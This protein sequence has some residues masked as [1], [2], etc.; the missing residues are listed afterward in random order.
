MRVNNLAAAAVAAVALTTAGPA[1]AYCRTASCPNK[2]TGA[3]CLPMKPSDCGIPIAWRTPCIGFSVQEDASSQVPLALAEELFQTA[4]TTWMTADCGGGTF[5]RIQIVYAGPVVCAD[6]E[7]NQTL[8]NANTIIFRDTGWPYMGADSTLALTTVTYNL[9][10]GDIYDADIE[11]NSSSE[12]IVFTTGDTGV[13][14]DLRSIATHEVGHFLGLSHSDEDGATMNRGYDPGTIDLRDLE[15]D[16]VDAICTT[17]PPGEVAA[18]D[19]DPTP[20]HGFA[21]ECSVD[22]EPMEESGCC[23]IAPGAAASAPGAGGPFSAG[24][25][26]GALALGFGGLLLCAARLRRRLAR[27]RGAERGIGQWPEAPRPRLP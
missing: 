2:M 24:S 18:A 11:V 1:S 20:R 27:P 16:D 19:C 7:Y 25:R 17:Y 22:Q 8:G 3:Q 21:S 4:F 26:R 14:F 9:D 23:S 6:H 12:S 15:P 10:T 5:P 13:Q